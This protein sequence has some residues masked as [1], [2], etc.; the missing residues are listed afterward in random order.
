MPIPMNMVNTNTVI[1]GNFRSLDRLQKFIN[2]QINSKSTAEVKMTMGISTIS[3]TIERFLPDTAESTWKCNII[4]SGF[5]GEI[6]FGEI[7]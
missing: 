5:C 2:D 7:T 1:N 4:V 6:I 3:E